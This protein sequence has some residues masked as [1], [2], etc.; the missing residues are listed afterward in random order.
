MSEH[1]IA[2]RDMRPLDEIPWSAGSAFTGTDWKKFD[3][4]VH[5][6]WGDTQLAYRNG[7]KV[8]T[9]VARGRPTKSLF[10]FLWNPKLKKK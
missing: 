6:F 5:R 8:R 4:A 2:A 10:E 3:F 1:S 7:K 9:N